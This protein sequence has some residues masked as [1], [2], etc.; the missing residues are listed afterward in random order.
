MALE[1]VQAQAGHGDE[2]YTPRCVSHPRVN[3]ND[4]VTERSFD[5][6]SADP[7]P[8]TNPWWPR[9]AGWWW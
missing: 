7:G 6:S 4:A 5:G 9:S 8:L 2:A 1:A 3:G